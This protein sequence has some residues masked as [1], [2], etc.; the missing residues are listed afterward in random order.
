MVRMQVVLNQSEAR[1][2]T[3]LADSEIREPRDQI[4]YI[5][6]QELEQRGLLPPSD[7][8]QQAQAQN[9]QEV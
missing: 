4:R 8:H 2:L 7:T 5:L 1:A 9:R 3:Q 6:R